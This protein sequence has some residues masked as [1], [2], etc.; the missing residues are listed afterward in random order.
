MKILMISTDS[1]VLAGG[2]DA[3]KRMAEYAGVLG[4]LHIIVFTF[5]R[6]P[7]CAAERY[8]PP[9]RVN[10]FF[11]PAASIS[12]IGR[13][14]HAWQIGRILCRRMRFDVISVQSPDEIGVIGWLLSRRFRVPLQVQVHT[15]IHS[16]R[17]RRASWKEAIRY[18]IARFLIPRSD[19]IRAASQRIADSLCQT[20]FGTNCARLSLAQ[21]LAHKITVLPIFTDI[22]K[23]AGASADPEI[24]RRFADYSFRMIA[25]GRFVEKEKHFSLLIEMMREF[26]K[27]CPSA[28]LV[29]VGEGPDEA[30]YRLPVTR[31][32][33]ERNVVIEPWR[34]D[35]PSFYRSFDLFLLSSN[36]EGWGRA[37]IEAMA[38]GL[39][40]VMTDVG[41]AGEAVEDGKNGR[42]V[43]V[44]DRQAFLAAV[45]DLYKNPVKRQA[46]AAA[47]QATARGLHPKTK[48]EY[49]ALYKRS[50]ASC[51]V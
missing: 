15:D 30:G 16:P 17:H 34:N 26:V 20:K 22:V 12:R 42:V 49:L 21:S 45:A 7:A 29:L 13:L 1:R 32:R 10:L 50:F 9:H 41:L 35:L 19:C 18:R 46:I 4:E 38:A 39:A 3:H 14:F 43:P 28:L 37:V 23:Y 47:G 11:Y 40:V 51:V 24:E 2:S 44:G 31:Y 27:I 36:Y 6:H 48:E 25:A 5:Q 33:L 8:L